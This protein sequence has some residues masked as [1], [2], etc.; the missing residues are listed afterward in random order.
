M[1]IKNI[2]IITLV[3]A[4]FWSISAYGNEEV[5]FYTN[6][7]IVL[8][9]H[10]EPDTFTVTEYGEMYGITTSGIS[11][12]QVNISNDTTRLQ[13]FKIQ[14]AWWYVSD[15]GLIGFGEGLSD[16][17]ALSIYLAMSELT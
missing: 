9:P 8:T 17:E 1:S 7:N 13:R 4:P 3:F 16:I 11:F 2:L 12:S 14:E 5:I 15:K 6:D 10:P